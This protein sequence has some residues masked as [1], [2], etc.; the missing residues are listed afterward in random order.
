MRFGFST[1]LLSVFLAGVATAACPGADC[2]G[3]G[4]PAA[5]DC[6][7]TWSGITAAVTTCVDGTAC[8]QD[9]V[10]DG[11]CTFPL[12]ACLGADPACGVTGV[13]SALVT[14]TKLA[15]A[16][17]LR[18][19]LQALTPGQCTTPGFAVPVK[20]SGLAPIKPGVALV[21]TMVAADGKKDRDK[22]KLTCL[23]AVP[24]FASAV[25]PILT[26]RCTQGACHN[27]ASRAQDLVLD[28]GVAYG[29]I[30]RQRASSF[31]IKLMRV[32]PGNIRKSFLARKILGEAIPPGGGVLMPQGCPVEMLATGGC[33]GSAEK[34][35]ILSWIQGGAPNN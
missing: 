27:A 13:T 7:V 31:G 20:G 14:P 34:Y 30:I 25:Q 32:V 21:K 1:V 12:Q 18:G 24:S 23:P 11:V 8:D 10:A 28:P 3:G 33:P 16:G 19:A 9:G 6:I 2:V 26:Q 29:S 17:A 5:T 22:L 15:S 35:T 4:G